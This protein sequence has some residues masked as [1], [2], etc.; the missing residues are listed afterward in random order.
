MDIRNLLTSHAFDDVTQDDAVGKLRLE[1][2]D[3]VAAAE[4]VEVVI[5]PVRVDLDDGLGLLLLGHR[6]RGQQRL[7][8]RQAAAERVLPRVHFRKFFTAAVVSKFLEK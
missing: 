4:F 3:L 7:L 8:R 6:P 1:V 5:G 2:L